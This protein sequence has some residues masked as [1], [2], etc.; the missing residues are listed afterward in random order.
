MPSWERGHIIWCGSLRYKPDVN[1][2][3]VWWKPG[4][5]GDRRVLR[6]NIAPFVIGE[7]KLWHNSRCPVGKFVKDAETRRLFALKGSVSCFWRRGN[8]WISHVAGG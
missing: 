8:V 1:L 2:L 3:V 4:A 7:H 5:V 6:R